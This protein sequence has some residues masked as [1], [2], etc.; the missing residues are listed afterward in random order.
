MMCVCSEGSALF[1]IIICFHTDM[2]FEL[3]DYKERSYK[4]M[5]L[6]VPI[7]ALIR[8]CGYASS[9]APTIFAGA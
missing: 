1:H 4:S 8:K 7:K 6:H 5:K 2:N 9:S 3:S